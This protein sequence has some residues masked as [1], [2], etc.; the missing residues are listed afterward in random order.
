MGL[1]LLIVRELPPLGREQSQEASCLGCVRQ[2]NNHHDSFWLLKFLS[3]WLGILL[4]MLLYNYVF[5]TS[6]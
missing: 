1:C 2:T 3:E 6:D 4:Y 5:P